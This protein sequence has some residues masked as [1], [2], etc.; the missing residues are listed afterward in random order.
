MSGAARDRTKLWIYRTLATTLMILNAV[1]IVAAFYDD[2][3]Y[4]QVIHGNSSFSFPD[5]TSGVISGRDTLSYTPDFSRIYREYGITHGGFFRVGHADR[6]FLLHCYGGIDIRSQGAVFEVKMVNEHTM[7]IL[8]GEESIEVTDLSGNS[9]GYVHANEEIMIDLV[10][11]HVTRKRYN[12]V[13]VSDRSVL[14]ILR[15]ERETIVSVAAQLEEI[16]DVDIRVDTAVADYLVDATFPAD[17]SLVEVLGMLET[18]ES[19]GGVVY[20]IV[21]D[22][23]GS[24]GY[25][26]VCRRNTVS[27][28]R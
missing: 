5:G 20:R 25:V 21:R 27:P 16:F 18:M 6:L 22:R 11:K 3:R 12:K 8:V 1:G 15:F 4:R 17:V 7:K 26:T 13:F 10:T 2:V 14:P 23:D 9:H 28:T 24:I 19:D